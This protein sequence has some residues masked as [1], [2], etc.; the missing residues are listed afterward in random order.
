M[1][2]AQWNRGGRR[3]SGEA[4]QK[5][6]PIQQFFKD[7]LVFPMQMGTWDTLLDLILQS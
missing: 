3:G 2:L 4:V 7:K 5:T 6:G 1:N